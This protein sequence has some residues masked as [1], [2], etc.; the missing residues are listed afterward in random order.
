MLKYWFDMHYLQ[1]DK[2][3]TSALYVDLQE[4][5]VL[6]NLYREKEVLFDFET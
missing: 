4:P 1:T 3:G 2:N 5:A 6:K